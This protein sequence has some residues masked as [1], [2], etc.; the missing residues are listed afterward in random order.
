MYKIWLIIILLVAIFF[1]F[2][3]L[4]SSPPG[5][6]W[7]EVSIGYN[8]YSILKTGKDEW[9]QFMP[10][11]FKA[12]GEHKLPG[13]IYASVPGIWLFGTTDLG[14]RVTPAL[15]GVFA[16]YLIYLLTK[17]LLNSVPQALIAS[18]L[19]AISPWAVHFSRVSFEAGLALVFVMASVYFLIDTKTSKQNLW[20]SMFFAVLGVYTYNSVRILLP[21][22]FIAY[23]CLSIISLKKDQWLG[24]S[25]VLVVALLL[26]SPV[27][28]GLTNPLERVRWGTLSILNQKSFTS[29]VAESRGYTTLPSILPRLIHNKATHY[30]YTLFTN[31]LDIF[32]TDFLYSRGGT[33]TQRSVQ[34]IG[35]LYKFEFIL[36]IFGI[37]IMFS[38]KS[39]YNYALKILL[40]W[41]LLA[42][43][44][45]I[46]TIDS[47]ST[48]RVLNMLPP[49]LIIE[50]IGAIYLFNWVKSRRVFFALSILF[51]FW[52]ISYFAYLLFFV[53]P[54]KYSD[55]WLYGYKEAVLW[56]DKYYDS[57]N[58]IYL[59]AKYGEPYIYTLF[60]T[61][62]DPHKFQTGPVS[63]EVDP[64]GW[65]H[66]SSFD[67]YIFTTFAGLE[68]PKE[69]VSRNSGELVMITGF[70][71]LPGEYNRDLVIKAPN[72][73]VVFEGTVQKGQQ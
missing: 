35:L 38:N 29:N 30:V 34:G 42:P 8:A 48:V 25:K 68:S 2:F 63:R 20:L 11:S 70:T 54:V 44:P 13:L 17:K 67:K 16:V 7:D 18:S 26:L 57:A 56:G 49:L 3:H 22:L 4:T 31:Y 23:S 73:K 36:L 21:I 33:N 61:G 64:L 66:V 52:S 9:G 15:L 27:I 58:K 62:F 6:N 46:L 53:Y 39:R 51:I 41:L 43:I 71:D 14:V 72:W 65:V 60:Y 69:I 1:R 59:T 32:S 10:L 19:L 40:P 12:F 47:P 37:Y 28:I 50:S 24:L 55:Q 5:L 45:S